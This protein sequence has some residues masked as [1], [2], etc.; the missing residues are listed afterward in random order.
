MTAEEISRIVARWTG[1]PVEKLVEGEREKLLRL[2]EVLHQRVIGQDEAVQKV[3]DAILRSR[4]GIANPNRP[5]GSFLFLGPTGVGKTEL[6]KALAQALFDDEKN[7]V[8]IDM[9]E[10]M[11]KFSVS[12]LIGAPPGYV[13]YEEGGQLTEAVRRKPYS[14][15][16]FDEVEKAHP[17]VFNILLQVLD[18]GRITDSQGRTVDFK[19]T[20]IILTS[21]LG[22]SYLLDGIDANG[23][24][25]AD[26]R[27]AVEALLKQSFR[28]EFLNRL[29]EIVFYKPLTRENIFSIVD[30]LMK[31]LRKRLEEQQLDVT[32]TDAAKNYIVDQG[33]DPIYGARPLKRFLQRK[34]ETL[35]A[36]ACECEP[37]ITADD[38]LLCTDADRAI[39]GLRLLRQLLKPRRTV[40][41]IEDNKERAV[42]ILTD[43]LKQQDEVELVV[44]PTRYPQGAEKQLIQ[45][46]TGRQVPSGGFPKDVG[47]AVFNIATCA[48][49][50]RAVADGEP[51]LRRIVTITGHGIKEPKN[52]IVPIGTPFAHA[53]EAAGGLQGDVWKVI[54]GGPMMGRSQADL[55]TP[56]IK[57]TNAIVAL[58]SADDLESPHPSCIRCGR[59]VSVCPMGLQPL[60]LYRFSRCRDVGMLRQYSILD[61]VECGCCAYTCPGKLPI[62]A[63]IRE[64]KQRVREE[65]S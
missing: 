49:V 12:R 28:P 50:C 40:I 33:Y 55:S 52:L 25:T 1:I 41:A 21:N 44:L 20:V 56:V 4:A 13:G 24:I 64:G 46:V 18:D 23:E 6:A 38:A 17:D 15:I 32:L 54:A 61:C 31:D 62:V 51:I 26:A 57:G 53:I 19:N 63:A 22:S 29:D 58:T 5:I 30:L 35:I 2:P 10:Y 42:S 59:C 45:A 39:R 43:K 27:A 14:V 36:N 65:P 37:Y 3:S 47:C 7:M 60:Y 34:V 9:T 16:L 48:S 8:R 11:E